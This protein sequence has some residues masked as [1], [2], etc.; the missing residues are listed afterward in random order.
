VFFA[1]PDRFEGQRALFDR[2]T[3]TVRFQG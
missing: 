2:I 3:A 1:P